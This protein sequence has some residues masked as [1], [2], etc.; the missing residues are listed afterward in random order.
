M[1]R[2]GNAEKRRKTNLYDGSGPGGGAAVVVDVVGASLT[3]LPLLPPGGQAG[4]AQAEGF[5]RG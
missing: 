1:C 5:P 3:V 2:G 4:R